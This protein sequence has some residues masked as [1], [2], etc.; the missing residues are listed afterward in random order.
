MAGG[1]PLSWRVCPGARTLQVRIMSK[2][3]T[4]RSALRMTMTRHWSGAPQALLQTIAHFHVLTLDLHAGSAG[5]SSSSSTE[6]S[7]S[8]GY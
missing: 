1:A 7:M 4:W 3:R 6:K 5:P 8:P 2:K